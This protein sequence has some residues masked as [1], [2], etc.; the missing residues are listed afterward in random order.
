MGANAIEATRAGKDRRGLR[1]VIFPVSRV[2]IDA[3]PVRVVEVVAIIR[4]LNPPPI[5]A[6]GRVVPRQIDLA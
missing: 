3:D 1:P 6:D 2:G 4:P 5:L